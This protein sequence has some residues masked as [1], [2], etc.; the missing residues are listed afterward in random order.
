M[1]KNLISVI[2]AVLFVGCGDIAPTMDVDAGEIATETINEVRDRG[3]FWDLF[4]PTRGGASGR[5]GA[6]RTIVAEEELV[7]APVISD[8][9]PDS[10]PNIP[11]SLT[12]RDVEVREVLD[13]MRTIADVNMIVSSE[14]SGVTSVA[15]ADIPW[16]SAME[17]ILS[18]NRLGFRTTRGSSV[19]EIYTL[20]ELSEIEAA[21]LARARQSVELRGLRD[22]Q[23]YQVTTAFHRVRYADIEN[24]AQ[25]VAQLFG[26]STE[27]GGGEQGTTIVPSLVIVPDPR[28]NSVMLRGLEQEVVA[29]SD[30]LETLDVPTQQVLIEAIVVEASQSFGTALGVRLGFDF[31][32]GSTNIGG[33]QGGAAEQALGNAAGSVFD[34]NPGGSNAAIGIIRQTSV[35]DLRAEISALQ[36]E[37]ISRIVS[38]PRVYAVDNAEARIF[39]GIEIPY[40]SGGAD[41][42]EPTFKEAGLSLVVTPTIT[43]DGNVFLEI[44]I[45]KDSP[46]YSQSSTTPSIDK[47]EVSTRLLVADGAVAV[48][49]GIMQTSSSENQENLPGATGIFR[50]IFGGSATETSEKELIIFLIPRIQ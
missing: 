42:G 3:A 21:E 11:V 17:T 6:G 37:G 36:E 14:V 49:G 15:M 29:A 41:G 24:V 46:N 48:I 33:L 4:R 26:A 30:L 31:T 40:E 5:L 34:F 9:I 32:S 2:T 38:N 7:R 19:L 43:G 1:N 44:K 16:R 50:N 35:G 12:L 47:S 13:V 8:A 39:Q 28:T 27:D 20:A 10:Y 23:T 18:S 22:G 45:N 25:Q